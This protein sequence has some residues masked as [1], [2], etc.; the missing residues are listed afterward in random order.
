[1]IRMCL[2]MNVIVL[3]IGVA[4]DIFIGAAVDE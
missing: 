2:T 4:D 3:L 1:M